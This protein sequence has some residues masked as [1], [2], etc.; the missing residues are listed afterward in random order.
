[1]ISI[2]PVSHFSSADANHRRRD[3]SGRRAG[4]AG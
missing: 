1:L 3:G 4:R 2:A